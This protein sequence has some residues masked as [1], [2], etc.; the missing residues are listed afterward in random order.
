MGEIE[1]SCLRERPGI[2]TVIEGFDEEK[3]TVQDEQNRVE[4]MG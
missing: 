2:T 1:M 4:V 3:W